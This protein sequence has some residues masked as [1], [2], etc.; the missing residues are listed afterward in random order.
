VTYTPVI[1]GTG[2]A[3]WA[4]LQRTR[5][6]Q[7]AAFDQSALVERDT[8][9]F[10]AN[11]GKVRTAEELVSDYRLLKVALG[12]FGLDDDINSKFFIRKVLEEGTL[13]D[14][15]FSN[16]LADKRYHAMSKAF[17]FDLSPPLSALSD[18]GAKITAAYKDRQF[19]VAVGEQDQNLRLVMGFD[20][21]LQTIAT[22]GSSENSMWFT[23]MATQPVRKVFEAA[24]NLPLA[25]G[26]LD[27]D[28]QLE[29]F[30]EKAEAFFGTSNPA[31]FLDGET[32]EELT[33]RFLVQAD[34]G[35]G[36]SINSP[37]SIALTLLQTPSPYGP[38][39]G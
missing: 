39:F 25:V 1:A 12:A 35:A 36:I 26:T 16:K 37:G 31:D 27:I 32:Q 11:V 33:R 28:R 4:F 9:Y 30:K 29:I 15:A 18:F 17:G 22:N 7:Q 38:L 34:L 8:A 6:T 23:I 19:E 3:G 14:D 21:E 20:R 13:S 2:N 24:F 5:E 10:E